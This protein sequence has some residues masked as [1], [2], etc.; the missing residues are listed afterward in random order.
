MSDYSEL[1]Q[2]QLVGEQEQTGVAEDHVFEESYQE[3]DDFVPDNVEA[4]ESNNDSSLKTETQEET[5]KFSDEDVIKYLSQKLNTEVGSFED[6]VHKSSVKHGEDF[7]NEDLKV[8]N[9]YIKNTGRTIDDYMRTQRIDI[10]QVPLENIN[11]AKLAEDNP[12]LSEE[13]VQLL[14]EEEYGK[15][16]LKKIT[17][18]MLDDEIEEAE[19]YNKTIE[20]SNKL[21]D[22]KI[23][24]D[25]E[26]A[27]E[28]FKGV[29]EQYKLPVRE[30]TV[31]S[32]EKPSFKEALQKD[33][34]ELSTLQYDLGGEKFTYEVT[35]NQRNA[36]KPMTPNDLIASFTKSD[37]TFDVQGWNALMFIKENGSELIKSALTRGKS[38]GREALERE[39]KNTT[40]GKDNQGANVKT[41]E[42][43][44]ESVFEALYGVRI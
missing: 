40:L 43:G 8:I 16:P 20:R 26:K 13:E 10:E 18:D 24:R 9:D 30:Q 42:V 2:E 23:K 14:F 1:I 4:V 3:T 36:L 21:R 28:Y 32:F 19:A 34:K 39:M 17:E 31:S 7:A 29:Q 37:G 27:K 11:M 35:D 6:L 41:K 12:S 22:I 33:V 44:M 38:E 25:G 5:P 15:K